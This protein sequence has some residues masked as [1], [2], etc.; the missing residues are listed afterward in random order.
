MEKGI[1]TL[2]LV[3][4]GFTLLPAQVIFDPAKVDEV[5]LPGGTSIVEIDGAKYLK[6]ALNAWNTV[7]NVPEKELNPSSMHFSTT[8]MFKEGTSGFKTNQVRSF[9]KLISATGDVG[10]TAGPSTNEFSQYT[11]TISAKGATVNQIQLAGQETVSW[12]AVVGDTMFLG[13]VIATDPMVI[14]DPEMHD[15]GAFQGSDEMEIVTIEDAKYLKVKLK[16]WNSF[17]SV[18]AKV[19]DPTWGEFVAEAK[20]EEGTSGYNTAQ[21]RTFIKIY[22]EDGDVGQ[23]AGAST[24]EFSEYKGEIK[25]LGGNVTLIQVAGQQT[26]SWGAV[27]GD[28]MYLGIVKAVK[29]IFK[30]ESIEIAAEGDAKIDVKGGTLQLTAMV[31]PEN[32]TNTSVTWSVSDESIAAISESGLLTAIANGEVKVTATA[33]DGS[34]VNGTFDVMISNQDTYVDALLSIQNVSIFPNPATDFIRVKSDKDIVRLSIISLTGSTVKV[35]ENLKANSE[36][37]LDEMAKG[38]FIVKLEGSDGQVVNMR[39]LKR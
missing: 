38:F 15:I 2:I 18:P 12:G 25:A 31:L 10:Q 39:L 28:Y 33:M 7:F 3:I 13:R 17:F 11:G 21:M 9:I 30:V 6:V 8:M 24:T 36:V 5:S 22:S 26:V 4:F 37:S 16:G 19:L 27:E 29:T 1:F 32:A 35:I 14:F 23:T 20:F 34:A